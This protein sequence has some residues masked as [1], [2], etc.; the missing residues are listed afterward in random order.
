MES[1]STHSVWSILPWDV[2]WDVGSVFFL[3]LTYLIFC[4]LGVTLTLAVFRTRRA[5]KNPEH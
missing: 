5:L 4:I 2:P 3:G 1:F